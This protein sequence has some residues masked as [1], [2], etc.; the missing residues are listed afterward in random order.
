M[1]EAQTEPTEE[2]KKLMAQKMQMKAQ[3]DALT[4]HMVIQSASTILSGIF[5]NNTNSLGG[6]GKDPLKDPAIRKK[7]LEKIAISVDTAITLVS[8][9]QGLNLSEDVKKMSDTEIKE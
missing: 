9:V 3:Q 1:S 5:A 7:R 8:Y 6:V 4:K 2:Q